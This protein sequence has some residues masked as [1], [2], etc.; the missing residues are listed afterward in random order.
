MQLIALRTPPSHAT[1]EPS[2]IED[3]KLYQLYH[4]ENDEYQVAAEEVF[5]ESFKERWAG[6]TPIQMDIVLSLK[7]GDVFS[8][9]QKI[10]T[11]EGYLYEANF[12]GNEPTFE[13]GEPI[14]LD[15]WEPL[16]LDD[17]TGA[18][19]LQYEV[20]KDHE[21]FR[22]DTFMIERIEL[23][24]DYNAPV[25]QKAAYNQIA[26]YFQTVLGKHVSFISHVH[27][28]ENPSSP[29]SH[30]FMECLQ[31]EKGVIYFNGN[32]HWLDEAIVQLQTE[33]EV[34][35]EGWVIRKK[36]NGELRIDAK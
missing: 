10:G 24:G 9:P 19:R 4:C 18:R 29:L 2:I 16:L 15:F 21:E 8:T 12:I 17:S 36:E 35:I 32:S 23:E 13:N 7:E 30:L 26:D 14:N 27:L 1:S 5:P 22:K 20:M 25:Y 6:L 3:G 11:V 34:N 31:L 28:K 33:G